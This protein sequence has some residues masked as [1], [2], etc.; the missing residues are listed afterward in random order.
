MLSDVQRQIEL[1]A[2]AS[3]SLLRPFNEN[4]NNFILRFL[5]VDETLF[6]H[7]YPESE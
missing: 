2:D 6:Y 1:T 4:P 5:I 3:M 7:F